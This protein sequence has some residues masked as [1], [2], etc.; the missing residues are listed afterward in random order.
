MANQNL[1]KG[2]LSEVA[3]KNGTGLAAGFM[4]VKCFVM[5]DV[6]GSMLDRDAGSGKTRY[7][8]ACEQLKHLQA[9]N[10]GEIAVACFSG[11]AQFCPGGVPVMIGDTT[12]VGAALRMML[13][14]DGAGIR[15]VLISD[16]EPD[17]EPEA[18]SM[19]AK[20]KSKIDTIFVGREDGYGRE[21]LRKLSAATGG[22]S[23]T[24][25]PEQLGKLEQNITKL[26]AA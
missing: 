24:N 15:L 4:N 12:D 22:I 3:K 23:I 20:F 25:A 13:M 18:L 14:A 1:V 10:P 2:S 9:E 16:G 6:S 26:I 8:M 17:N 7:D 21:F 19:A 5:V 11:A